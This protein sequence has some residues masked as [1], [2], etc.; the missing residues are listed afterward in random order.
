MNTKNFTSIHWF[1]F[2]N[3]LFPSRHLSGVFFVFPYRLCLR[4]LF[5]TDLTTYTASYAFNSNLA[6]WS[7][8]PP[9]H[10]AK[11]QHVRPQSV[12]SATGVRYETSPT[13][14]ATTY[15][16]S[17]TAEFPLGTISSVAAAAAA[18]SAAAAAASLRTRPLPSVATILQTSFTSHELHRHNDLCSGSPGSSLRFDEQHDHQ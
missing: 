16:T 4:N 7:I 17:P 18:A 9:V 12:L 14:A 1:I 5:F 13:A 8:R 3:Y 10:P 11:Q 6:D 2:L 15:P